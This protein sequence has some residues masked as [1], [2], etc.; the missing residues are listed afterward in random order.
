[1]TA[2]QVILTYSMPGALAAEVSLATT[3]EGGAS[4]YANISNALISMLTGGADV[5]N[6]QVPW[7]AGNKLAEQVNH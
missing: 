6:T 2:L 1:M 5:Q 4:F 7:A 3:D